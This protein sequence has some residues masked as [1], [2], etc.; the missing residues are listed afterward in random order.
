M[1]TNE[2]TSIGGLMLSDFADIAAQWHPTRNGTLTPDQIVAGSHRKVWWKCSE[3]PD[4]EWATQ[5]SSR[6]DSGTGCPYCSGK[7][8]S[9]TN[10]LA[11]L[12]PDLAAQWHPT[13]NGALTPDQ[14]VAGSHRKVWWK[15]LEGPDPEWEA[16]LHGR[17]GSGT[18]CPYCNSGW[19]LAAIR[20]FVAS[21][22]EH[23]QV[24]TPAELYLLFQQNGLLTS[25]GKGKTEVVWEI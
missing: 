6:T 3:G 8:L 17:A 4:H 1:A 19:T 16:T 10:S 2:S 11:S 7:K 24:F 23:L 5:L 22:K 9:V 14:I 18:G 20:A 21:L 15:C 25:W 13:R 12:L